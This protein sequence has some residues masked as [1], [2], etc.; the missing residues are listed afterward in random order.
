MSSFFIAPARVRSSSTSS[1]APFPLEFAQPDLH[2]LQ[3]G[4]VRQG[5]D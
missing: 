3:V 1:R 2:A 4:T 5:I